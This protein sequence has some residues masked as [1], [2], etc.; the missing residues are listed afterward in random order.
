MTRRSVPRFRLFEYGPQDE[1]PLCGTLVNRLLDFVICPIGHGRADI[2]LNAGKRIVF[3]AVKNLQ[4]SYSQF[5]TG[6]IMSLTY[7]GCD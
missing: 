1:K 6:C 5:C 7:S 2:G 3:C 4:I